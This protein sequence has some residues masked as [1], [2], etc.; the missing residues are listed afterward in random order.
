[1]FICEECERLSAIYADLVKENA[2]ILKQYSQALYAR[3]CG[4]IDQLRE[5]LAGIEQFRKQ[6]REQLDA[7]I[8]THR[9]TA[10]S[11]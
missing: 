7:H 10:A 6:A 4:K 2:D 3:D 8:D 1:M 9:A 11:A 5:A